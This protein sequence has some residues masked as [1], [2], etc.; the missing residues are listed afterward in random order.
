MGDRGQIAIQNDDDKRVYLYSHWAGRDIPAILQSALLRGKGRWLD[1]CYLARI[2]FNEMTK[3]REMEETGFGIDTVEHEDTSHPIP[4]LNCTTQMI[5]WEKGAYGANPREP[6]SFA[7]YVQ[8]AADDLR[9]FNT[10]DEN[11]SED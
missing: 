10:N 7:D 11:L 2:V 3:G 9:R 4:V 8:L 6:I 5:A 1:D